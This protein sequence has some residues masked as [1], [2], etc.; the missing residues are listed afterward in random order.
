MVKLC[1]LKIFLKKFTQ[2]E[3]PDFV[4]LSSDDFKP[5]KSALGRNFVAKPTELVYCTKTDTILCSAYELTRTVASDTIELQDSRWF[6]LRLL[7]TPD[8]G[9]AIQKDWR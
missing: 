6:S 1:K 9:N 3:G 8:P 7:A 2:I 5:P 4:I